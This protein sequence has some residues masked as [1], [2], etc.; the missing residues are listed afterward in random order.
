MRKVLLS[1]VALMGVVTATVAGSAPAEAQ[2]YGWGVAVQPVQYRDWRW[3]ERRH[4][5][6]VRW[7][8]H[9]EWRRR[10]DWHH[11]Y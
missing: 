6:W 1:A 11:G 9:E 7:H 8:R 5:E 4:E 3:R 2:P 10:H